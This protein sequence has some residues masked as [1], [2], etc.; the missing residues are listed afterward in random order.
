MLSSV[1]DSEEPIDILTERLLKKTNGCIAMTFKKVRITQHK[2]CKLD[3]L[4]D[5]MRRLKEENKPDELD[6]VVEE[7]ATYKQ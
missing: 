5:K 1:L 7:I 4:Q 3:K 2:E 6:K